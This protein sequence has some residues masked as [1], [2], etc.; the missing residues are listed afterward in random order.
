MSSHEEH[1][2][3]A[4]CTQQSTQKCSGC[5]SIR[6]CSQTCQK[7][8]WPTHKLVCKDYLPSL[9]TQPSKDYFSVIYFPF[10]EDK[11]RS[12]WMRY[13]EGHNHPHDSSFSELGLPADWIET[14]VSEI[15]YES[16]ILKRRY[17]NH[18]IM[19]SHPPVEQICPCYNR[20]RKPSQSLMKLDHD[21]AGH[22]AGAYVA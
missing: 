10:N 14:R 16:P 2:L 19:I 21:L 1:S 6:Y 9:L 12:A 22:L 20:D 7:K 8:D 15:S 18:R 5:K 4:M 11:P 3:Y 13:E 17:E